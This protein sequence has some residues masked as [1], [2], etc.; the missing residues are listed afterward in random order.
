MKKTLS[1]NR[2]TQ[3]LLWRFPVQ[4]YGLCQTTLYMHLGLWGRLKSHSDKE[5]PE[6][7]D[8]RA[9]TAILQGSRARKIS[10]L[11]ETEVWRR[12]LLQFPNPHS[13]SKSECFYIPICLS[14]LWKWTPNCSSCP[15][16]MSRAMWRNLQDQELGP[17]HFSKC[18]GSCWLPNVGS[19]ELYRDVE[20]SSGMSCDTTTAVLQTTAYSNPGC[21]AENPTQTL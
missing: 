20:D 12:L 18:L 19:P 14:A 2:R 11:S 4:G 3:Q 8:R 1:M 5:I 15:E 6:Y 10:W 16:I 9:N 7:S 21:H 13:S 17:H